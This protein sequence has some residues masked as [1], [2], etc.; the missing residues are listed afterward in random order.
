VPYVRTAGHIRYADG[1]VANA[2]LIK[3]VF[4][5]WTMRV[6]HD[7]SLVSSLRAE[8]DRL[9]VELVDMSSS[10][11]T[12]KMTWR[13]TAASDPTVGRFLSRDLDSRLSFREKAAV[14]EWVASGKAFHV[15]RDH[16]EHTRFAMSGGMW[17]AVAGALPQMMALVQKQHVPGA[18]L[19]DMDFLTR[20]V[21][22]VAQRSVRQHDRFACMQFGGARG[23]STGWPTPR[24]G[25][26]HV[27][28]VFL[29]KYASERGQDVALLSAALAPP[30][31]PPQRT[32][33][34][35]GLLSTVPSVFAV[36]GCAPKLRSEIGQLGADG[37]T[38]YTVSGRTDEHACMLAGAGGSVLEPWVGS[39]VVTV[40]CR[41]GGGLFWWLLGCGSAVDIVALRG[42]GRQWILLRG[43]C[44]R[45][46]LVQG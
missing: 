1:A 18:Y 39:A 7:T 19:G 45:Q 23:G 24:V 17:G 20:H 2:I 33:V 4:P 15:M 28:S 30:P 3:H 38:A 22:P 34:D 37:W 25:A 26:E 13:F 41:S 43:V 42:V 46:L 10:P 6:Y 11:L 31:P 12:N 40:G 32:C 8:L 5:G 21:W 27:G 16:P 35:R 14:D 44:R 36:P 9:G 29:D